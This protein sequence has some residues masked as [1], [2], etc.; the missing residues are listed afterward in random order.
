MST[1]APNRA[2]VLSEID[3]GQPEAEHDAQAIA[4]A[5]YEA[6][7]WKTIAAGAERPFVV[8]RKGSGK[9]AIAA[10]L[11]YLVKQ[12]KDCCFLQI[13]PSSF[14][15]VEIRDLL[16]C[17]VNKNA[18][19]QYIYRKVWEG[20]ILGQIVR[21]IAQCNDV[22]GVDRFPA[23][24]YTEMARFQLQCGFYVA[25]VGDA[26]S[27]VIT[28]YVR[29][30]TKKTDAL[31]Q[32]ELRQMLEPYAW[33]PFVHALADHFKRT[34]QNTTLFI[35]IDGLDE[36][37][38]T[39]APSLYFLAELLAVAK[40]FTA[41]FGRPVRFIVCLRDSIFR[42]LVDT[43][44]IEYDKI[45]SLIINLEW[46]TRALFEL[47]ARRV[48]P[49]RKLDV[50]VS[51]LRA[52][53][54]ETIDDTSIEEYLARHVLQRP[55]DYINFFRMLKA[56]CGNEPR[57][58]EGHVHDALAK[59]SANR[60]MDLENE[61]GF[62]YPGVSKLITAL[63]T[64]P[65]LFTKSQILDELAILCGKPSFR[66]EA[67]GLILN[68]G[69]PQVLARIL[70]SIGA[71]GTYD[72]SQHAI[73]FVHE[74]SETR[75]S[76]LWES[77]EKLSIHPVYCYR[78]PQPKKSAASNDTPPAILTHPADYLA[79]KNVPRADLED[80]DAKME[81]KREDLVAA[82]PAIEK[83]QQHYRRFEE[84]ARDTV[85]LCFI[86]DLLNAEEQIVAASKIKRFEVVFDIIGEE[87]PWAEIKLKYKTHRLLVECKNTDEP[88]DADVTKLD[89]DMAALDVNV[90]F[91]AYRG[92]TREPRGKLLAY[93]RS[94]YINSQKQR[95]I[96][97]LSEAF[98]LQCLSKKNNAKCRQVLN[99]LW[100][101]HVQ[102][103][104]AT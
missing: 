65:E 93:L 31:S 63:N 88:T 70:L 59:Y 52:L 55:R 5:F 21:H 20:I 44:S 53:L 97:S 101:D 36:H 11:E 66:A 62:T 3:F 54:P 87:P 56:E 40:N 103:W 91:L 71:I 39:S 57:A 83:G 85:S 90:A 18:S 37:W 28:K 99:S 76:A 50:A 89:R 16:N 29:E 27:A 77:S 23:D 95:V 19:W 69:Q 60:L 102:R 43:K 13:V 32:V 4:V 79:E 61:F 15:H 58:G 92:A 104:L 33:T 73:R 34:W 75:V 42:A 100:R 98:L 80:Y 25:S 41:T 67:P 46:N 30:S 86:G 17:L 22:H 47:I 49:H 78:K 14:R 72:A 96:V 48:A 7:S 1:L 2:A 12:R 68:Y 9:S 81:R 6:Q 45:E 84:W 74:F 82:L 35:A 8:G 64:L 51:E 26:L 94:G 24:L 10:R 38:D